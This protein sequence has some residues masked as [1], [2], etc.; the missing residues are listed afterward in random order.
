MITKIRKNSNPDYLSGSDELR[1]DK[2]DIKIDIPYMTAEKFADKRVKVSTETFLHIIFE[3]VKQ[4]VIMDTL[5]KSVG[6]STCSKPTK[7]ELLLNGLR[8]LRIENFVESD[9]N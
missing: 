5:R 6:I 8:G 1:G 9:Q 2:K 7:C 4:I 3:I